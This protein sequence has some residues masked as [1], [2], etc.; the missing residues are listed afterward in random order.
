[1]WNFQSTKN[2]TTQFAHVHNNFQYILNVAMI[3]FAVLSAI[4]TMARNT[5][6][7]DCEKRDVYLTHKITISNP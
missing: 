6:A 7:T 1:M 3:I 2:I 5:S 4:A